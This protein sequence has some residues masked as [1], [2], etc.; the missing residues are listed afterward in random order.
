MTLL[1]IIQACEKLL[2]WIFKQLLLWLLNLSSVKVY[3]LGNCGITRP[4]IPWFAMLVSYYSANLLLFIV[5]SILLCCSSAPSA[6]IIRQ[7][8]GQ[9]LMTCRPWLILVLT[10]FPLY[11]NWISELYLLA[12]WTNKVAGRAW[13]PVSAITWYSFFSPYWK[14]PLKVN[15]C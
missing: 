12:V 8:L 13:I 1:C 5:S 2:F 15:F 10:D 9:H 7:H 4:A 11:S 14:S 3:T 6:V